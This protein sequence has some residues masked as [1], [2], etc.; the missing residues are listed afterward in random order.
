MFKRISAII[1][2]TICPALAGAA[3]AQAPASSPATRP[4]ATQTAAT[5]PAASRPAATQA[6]QVD[7]NV[8]KV[9]QLLEQKGDAVKDLTAGI[10]WRT[11]DEVI[12]G[13]D[14][15]I[16]TLYFKRGTPHDQFLVRFNKK[17][18][19]GQEID[20]LEEHAFDGQWYT[21]KREA[22][23]NIIKR[24]I[25]RPGEKYDPFKLGEGPFPLPFGQKESE[26]LDKF[27]VSYVPPAKG[28]PADSTHLKLIPKPTSGDLEEKYVDMDFY[29]DKKIDL[30]VKVVAK[31]KE[32]GKIVTVLFKDIKVN[33]GLPGSTFILQLPK[34]DPTWQET[35][36]PLTPENP[37]GQ[38]D[39]PD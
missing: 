20:T 11:F 38:S 9:L 8:H 23:K 30:P 35:V 19:D 26:I 21:E 36:E 5:Q 25:V 32:D 18:S 13:E 7:P 10:T 39:L 16:G 24:E 29:V 34:D 28:D 4:A 27:D 31:Q 1:A 12:N 37:A 22:T 33:T 6:A 2:V 3:F 15:L 17:I 14:T